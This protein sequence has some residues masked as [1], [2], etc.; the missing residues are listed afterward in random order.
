MPVGWVWRKHSQENPIL[1]T[2]VTLHNRLDLIEVFYSH[3]SFLTSGSLVSFEDHETAALLYVVIR[4]IRCEQRFYLH[5]S[6]TWK[7][8][9]ISENPHSIG[10]K[11][12]PYLSFNQFL[13]ASLIEPLMPIRSKGVISAPIVTRKK[14]IISYDTTCVMAFPYLASSTGKAYKIMTGWVHEW[15]WFVGRSSWHE[16]RDVAC[17]CWDNRC[18]MVL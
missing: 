13:R 3:H 18:R 7:D 16:V 15:V 11:R 12:I 9:Q 1:V 5:K 2:I 8:K 4:N 17:P 6:G 14:P 10:P